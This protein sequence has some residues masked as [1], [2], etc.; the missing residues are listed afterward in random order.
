MNQ[1]VIVSINPIGYKIEL[2][3]ID[4]ILAL[5]KDV[6]SKHVAHFFKIKPEELTR[7]IL[8]RYVSACDKMTNISIASA[9]EDIQTKLINPLASAKRCY[10]YDET[11]ACIELC[12][13]HGEMICNFLCI[14]NE[15]QLKDPLVVAKLSKEKQ[16]KINKHIAKNNFYDA[17]N[18]QLR[19]EWLYCSNIIT[20]NDYQ[21]LL[22]VHET[23]KKYFHHW[24]HDHTS[25]DS[26]ALKCLE[27]LSRVTA[28]YL[29]VLDTNQN[30]QIIK[31]YISS[32][33][34]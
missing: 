4:N 6:I 13:M 32:L 22:I 11:L 28:K 19:L 26:D 3:D 23:R 27:L 8:S 5:P 31:S 15:I 10:S 1:Q 9:H 20:Q 7:S 16:G 21:D 34:S 29:E 30:I 14:I 33:V 12:A 17:M 24:G 2:A 18:Q 25:L